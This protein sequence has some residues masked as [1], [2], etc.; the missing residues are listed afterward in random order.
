M[1]GSVKSVSVV[2]QA[3]TDKFEKK[4]DKAGK[5]M[6]GFVKKA[7]GLAAGFVGARAAIRGLSNA[8]KDLDR[9]GKLS[10]SLEIDPTTLMGLDFAATQ[11]GTSFEVMTKG[12]QRMVQTIGEA[13]SGMSTGTLALEE[14]GMSANDFKGLNAEDAFMKMADGIAAIEG[15]AQKAAAANRLFGRSGREL[16]NVLNQGSEGIRRYIAEQRELSGPISI[17]DIRKIEEAKDSM[18]KMRRAVDGIAQQF[19]IAL[20]PAMTNI[21]NLTK[22]LLKFSGKFKK[23]WSEI[24]DFMTTTV[25]VFTAEL[26]KA[27]AIWNNLFG[28]LSFEEMQKELD[29]IEKRLDGALKVILE[30]GSDG[31]GGGSELPVAIQPTRGFAEAVSFQSSKAFDILN[32]AKP[33]SIAGKNAAANEKT[34]KATTQIVKILGENTTVTIIPGG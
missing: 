12:I 23:V 16:L 3:F 5:K 24:Q 1:A 8:M 22:D 32:P 11:T 14:L 10:D 13:R 4:V 17:E 34:A 15:P 25:L 31:E 18:D 21:L 27:A 26:E 6:G 20:A 29:A 9:I 2:F 33:N 7:A 19:A 28:D 30:D